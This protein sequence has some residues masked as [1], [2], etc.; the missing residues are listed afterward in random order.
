MTRRT[1]LNREDTVISAK[2]YKRIILN[3]EKDKL[4]ELD[5]KF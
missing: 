4:R 5:R 1:K 3:I 2:S